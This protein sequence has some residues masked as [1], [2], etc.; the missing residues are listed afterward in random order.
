MNY[1]ESIQKS[2]H[3][4]EESLSYDIDI[5]EI[6]EK[7][8]ISKYHFYRLFTAI[9]GV[10]PMEYIR[11]RRISESAKQLLNSNEKII[12]IALNAG[13]DSQEAF[14]RAFKQFFNT[15]PAKVRKEKLKLC[16]YERCF[17]EHCKISIKNI[18]GGVF[19]NV[20][21]LELGEIKLVG[22]T[23]KICMPNNTI[24]Q[25]WEKVMQRIHEIKNIIP[26]CSYGVAEN[27]SDDFSF[28]ETVG[29]SV[30]SFE[31]IPEGMITK[32]IPSQKYL[33]FTHKGLLF[34]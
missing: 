15:T 4:I 31:D 28:D 23:E 9:I 5:D 12:N 2:V 16:L 20:K 32:T 22:I 25:L 8:Y 13:F 26:G 21:E 10:P 27:M 30:S 18:K 33:V 29:F 6:A 1:T 3:L 17:I 7:I 11:K 14:T 24:P 19:M 34:L